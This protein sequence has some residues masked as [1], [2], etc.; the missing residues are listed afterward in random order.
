MFAEASS[1]APAVRLPFARAPDGRLRW[2]R[3]RRRDET[4][5]CVGCAAPVVLRAGDVRRA[6]YAHTTRAPCSAETVLHRGTIEILAHE[7]ESASRARR[8]LVARQAC[9]DCDLVARRDLARLSDLRALREHTLAGPSGDTA[10]PDLL[11]VRGDAPAYAVEVVVTHA[12]ELAARAVL[13]RR[14]LPIVIVRPSWDALATLEL[15]LSSVSALGEVAIEGVRCPGWRHPPRSGSRCRGCGREGLVCTVQRWLG[16]VC[17]RCRSRVPFADVR[18]HDERAADDADGWDGQPF[19]SARTLGAAIVPVATA[20]GVLVTERWTYRA[21][22]PEIVHACPECGSTQARAA[23]GADGEPEAVV[24][25]SWCRR[26]DRVEPLGVPRT[27]P[28]SRDPV[29]PSPR[30]AVTPATATTG[31]P[32]WHARAPRRPGRSSRGGGR[33][34]GWSSRT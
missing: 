27:Q 15:P 17:W 34:W 20:L 4:C 3:E 5:V 33:T 2:A 29:A 25:V 22:A 28:G 1:I 6:H 13:A 8:P 10:R 26:C 14:G 16:S 24:A 32:P 9:P 11:V 18:L 19:A 21:G 31:A 30:A 7:I 12:P 23:R